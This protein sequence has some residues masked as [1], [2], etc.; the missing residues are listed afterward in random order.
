MGAFG[1]CCK[2][3]IDQSGVKYRMVAEAAHYDVSYVSKWVNS[4]VL[5]AATAAPEICRAIAR[6][7]AEYSGRDEESTRALFQKTNDEFYEAYL[8]DSRTSES[9]SKK[10]AARKDTKGADR[11]G[12][13]F[14]GLRRLRDDGKRC[15]LTIC[16][17][18]ASVEQRELVFIIDVLNYVCELDF[19]GG[20]VRVMLPE[21][22][23][24][25]LDD[26]TIAV[27]L[28][29]LF[30]VRSRVGLKCYRSLVS[31]AGLMVHADTFLYTA[32]CWAHG[33]WL[34]EHFS[35]DEG[36]TER[37]AQVFERDI[38]PTAHSMFTEAPIDPTCED[39]TLEGMFWRVPDR[40]LMGSACGVFCSDGLLESLAAYV[41]E[42]VAA[43]YAAMHARLVD[44]LEKG[45][46]IRCIFYGQA[47]EN[48]VYYGRLFAGG[49]YVELSLGDRFR[50]LQDLTVLFGRYPNL[51]IKVLTSYVVRDVK[52]RQLP[53]MSLDVRGV[54]FV[55][56][57]TGSAT[58]CRFSDYAAK[59]A[60]E[61][62][63]ELLWNADGVL[64]CDIRE[65]ISEYFDSCEAM[66][67]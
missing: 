31:H 47:F 55:P 66:M 65:V 12:L 16:G 13:V 3:V 57:S 48:L 40:M 23:L 19:P 15:E 22:G 61:R 11:R 45:R 37:F 14:E 20:E 58:F 6:L 7:V 17:D 51:Q 53:I 41:G 60:Y 34:V 28:I 26:S 32:Q 56:F 30:M 64:L 18:L 49:T 8:L 29:N 38:A 42:D 27:A 4:D 21:Q 2:K 63:Y 44:L 43:R 52:H 67:L 39:D 25:E 10:K 59:K 50:Y 54:T 62:C 9:A 33:E 46:T 5:P 1:T 35:D 24:E 36:E